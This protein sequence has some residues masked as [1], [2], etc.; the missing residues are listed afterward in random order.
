ML[1]LLLTGIGLSP[2]GNAADERAPAVLIEQTA[3]TLAER[4]T[5]DRAQLQANPAEL[6]ALVDEVF[7]PVFDTAYAGQLVLGRHRRAASSQQR[8]DFVATFY[9]YLVRSYAGNVL[10]FTRD[11]MKVFPPSPGASSNPERAVVRTQMS[12]DDGTT[13]AVDYSLRLTPEG[14][15]I[16]DVRIEGISY[17]QTYRNQFDSEINA[18]GLD[19]VIARL[20]SEATQMQN[21]SGQDAVAP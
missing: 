1:W 5:A 6:Y 19:A 10:Q 2:A 17:V 14:W 15:R 21:Q 12:L 4:V 18:R 3:N 11:N 7:L 8:R 9:A 13:A 16:F 20:Q